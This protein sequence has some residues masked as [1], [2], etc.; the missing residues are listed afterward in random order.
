LLGQAALLPERFAQE[1]HKHADA[2]GFL[3]GLGMGFEISQL[4]GKLK[5][6]F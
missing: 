5:L 4:N 2:G 6:R 1:P 3:N